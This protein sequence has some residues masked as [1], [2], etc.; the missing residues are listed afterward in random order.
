MECILGVFCPHAEGSEEEEEEEEE[1]SYGYWGRAGKMK[2]VAHLLRMW[3]TGNHR[4]LLF[5]QSKGM[6]NILERFIKHRKYSYRR[7]DGS[8]PVSTRQPMVNEFNRVSKRL[9]PLSGIIMQSNLAD[10]D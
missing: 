9:F 5:S 3:K 10:C 6:L 1:E 4:V 7:M 8:T 2:A